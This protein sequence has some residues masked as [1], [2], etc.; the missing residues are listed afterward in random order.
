[1]NLLSPADI[2]IIEEA[3]QNS[4]AIKERVED[5]KMKEF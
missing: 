4:L 5:M 3:K 1:M 2:G